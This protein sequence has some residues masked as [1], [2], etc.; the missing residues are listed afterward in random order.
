VNSR[1]CNPHQRS[2]PR[3]RRACPVRAASPLAT[4]KVTS[5]LKRN[6][7][8]CWSHCHFDFGSSVGPQ[9]PGFEK[10]RAAAARR[11]GGGEPRVLGWRVSCAKQVGVAARRLA[12]QHSALAS[13]GRGAARQALCAMNAD[14]AAPES[15]T[16]WAPAGA[17]CGQGP[18]P[19]RLR[20]IARGREALLRGTRPAPRA[21]LHG[22]ASAP[23]PR[24][25]R[26]RTPR[27]PRTPRTRLAT[28]APTVRARRPRPRAG[29]WVC[30]VLR[31]GTRHARAARVRVRVRRSR[32]A[33][34]GPPAP[35]C[36]RRRC[37]L[38]YTPHP[39]PR[40]D[41]ARCAPRCTPGHTLSA[42]SPLVPPATPSP[43]SVCLCAR[44]GPRGSSSSASWSSRR[45]RGTPPCRQCPAPPL[46]LS[47][48][49]ASLT[50]Y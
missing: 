1:S 33:R 41:R 49:A 3:L 29:V 5:R 21:L 46:V 24:T 36:R 44:Q 18:V 30:R 37:F 9:S 47:G 6:R 22:A 15:S 13:G 11:S 26:T 8:E 38:H 19:H 45:P 12:G 35:A 48:H 43:L 34:D 25:P 10:A 28:D 7:L 50:P 16:G 40:A 14:G 20:S 2:L 31:R 32:R 27:T 17:L 42:L 39:P 4:R 23:R